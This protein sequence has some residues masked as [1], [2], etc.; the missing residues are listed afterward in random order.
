MACRPR[1]IG[2]LLQDL[3][4]KDWNYQGLL[5][6]DHGAIN[7]LVLHGV[8]RDTRDAAEQALK[9]GVELNMHDDVYGKQLPALLAAGKVTQ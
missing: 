4:R 1:P 5:I 2:W 9:A 6:S 8:A 3:L 7:E